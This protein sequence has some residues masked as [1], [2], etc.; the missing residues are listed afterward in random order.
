MRPLTPKETDDQLRADV[1]LQ[2]ELEPEIVS[3]DISVAAKDGVVTLTGFV[4]TYLEKLAAEKAVKSVYGVHAVA[5]DIEVG[6]G[7]KRSDPE[8]A[9]DIVNAMEMTASIP[10]DRIKICVCEGFVTLEG[11]LDWNFQRESAEN[12]ARG[13]NGV[14]GLINKIELQPTIS[15]ALVKKK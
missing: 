7:T 4:H 6:P 1:L 14:R 10:D 9:R 8:I 12:T 11:T 5:G 2:L 15:T 13:I 3:K